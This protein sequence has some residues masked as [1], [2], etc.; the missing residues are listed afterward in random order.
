METPPPH[1]AAL[2][3]HPTAMVKSSLHS[4]QAMVQV[5]GGDG[6]SEIIAA[7]PKLPRKNPDP[8]GSPLHNQ[9]PHEVEFSLGKHSLGG[10]GVGGTWRTDW[11]GK[12]SRSPFSQTG[13]ATHPGHSPQRSD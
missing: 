2:P 10:F 7:T 3:S 5:F 8:L 1:P 13:D 9:I 4:G 11:S 12:P 6:E